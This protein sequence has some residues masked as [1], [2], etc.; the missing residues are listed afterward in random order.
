MDTTKQR[1]DGVS[2]IK[3]ALTKEEWKRVEVTDTSVGL[4]V[5]DDYELPED[6]D[7]A[8]EIL[9]QRGGN[10]HLMVA[11]CL[12]AQPFGFTRGDVEVVREAATEA[13]W[14]PAAEEQLT[15][16]ADRIEALLPPEDT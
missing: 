4:R 5:A 6:V 13:I 9:V 2:E 1:E 3:P 7:K 10:A 16:L 8:F 14:A 11:L 12:H 15:S